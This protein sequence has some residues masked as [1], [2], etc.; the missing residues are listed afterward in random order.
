MGTSIA[1][2]T[3]KGLILIDPQAFDA[4]PFDVASQWH[5]LMS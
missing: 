3:Y 4:G 5:K 2:D 1:E